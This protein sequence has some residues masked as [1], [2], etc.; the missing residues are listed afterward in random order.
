MGIVGMAVVLINLLA[1][2]PECP[3]PVTLDFAV[4]HFLRA[5]EA[6]RLVALE[7]AISQCLEY[8]IPEVDGRSN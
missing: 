6:E 4:H 3:G 1:G 8:Q 7:Y 5:N 2:P